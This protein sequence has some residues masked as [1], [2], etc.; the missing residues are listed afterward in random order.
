MENRLT[1]PKNFW[2]GCATSGPQTEGSFNKLH[3]NIFDHWFKISPDTFHNNIGPDITSNFYHSYKEDIAL[4]SKIGINTL[5]TSIQWT[6]LI[7]DLITGEPCEDGIQF[8]NNVIDECIRNNITPIINLHHFDIPV[9]LYHKYG[10]W[11]SRYVVDLFVKFATTA[12]SLFADKVKYWTTFNEPMV[13]VEGQYLYGFHYPAIIDAKKAVLAL[14]HLNLASAMTIKSLKELHSDCKIGI[15]LNLTPSYPRSLENEDDINAANFSDDFFNYSFLDPAVKG[16]FPPNLIKVFEKHNLL[17]EKNLTDDAIIKNNTVDF[18][19][20]NYY[21]PRRVKAKESDFD[22]TNGWLPQYYF[23]SYEMPNRRM[24]VYRGWEIYPKAVYDIA[25]NIKNNYNNIPWFL[26]E[27]GMGVE[28]EGR[29]KNSQGQINDTYRIDFYKE[30]LSYL[31]QGI[32]EGSNCF[33]FHSWTGFDCWSWC[34]AYK[35]RY[36]YISIDLE[37]QKRT[38]KKSGY[39]MKS[40]SDENGF[41]L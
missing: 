30:H 3:D 6:R 38:I 36:G 10:G 2:W 17:W 32:S 12:F 23:D 18:L 20:I 15:I 11:E 29:F 24:N 8:Y 19:G 7:K 26:S 31:H 16:V 25:I 13:V 5:R 39:W 40:V 4:L 14:Y 28:D 33:G 35:N 37:S 34:N 27:N 41:I 9:E 1:F 22:H 21:Q